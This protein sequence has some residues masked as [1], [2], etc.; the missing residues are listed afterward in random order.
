MKTVFL[1]G[2]II[3]GGFF[4]Y[5]GI[6]H[7]KIRHI[8]RNMRREK[9]A[10]PGVGGD[11]LGRSDGRGRSEHHPGLKPKIGTAG[12]IAFLAAFAR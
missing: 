8:W 7:F 10:E 3:F 1:I 9:C 11:G 4:L 12:I 2:R 6:N 5:N